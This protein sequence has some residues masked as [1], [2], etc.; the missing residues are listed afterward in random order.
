MDHITHNWSGY[1]AFG[2]GA[3]HYPQTIAEV[4]E[5]VRRSAKLRPIGAR[6]SFH[7]IADTTGDLISLRRM[8]RRIEIDAAQR[9]VT[10]DGGINYAELSPVLDAAGWALPNLAS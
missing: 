10:V 6:H 7:D 3:T 1:V 9:T 2:A 8:N 5:I 4:Q